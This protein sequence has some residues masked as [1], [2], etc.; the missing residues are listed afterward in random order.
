MIHSLLRCKGVVYID[1]R[2]CVQNSS[3]RF[4]IRSD[5]VILR[6][7]RQGTPAAKLS[8]GMSRVTTLPAPMTQLSPIVT[9][10]Q[11]VT[12]APNQQLSPMMTGFA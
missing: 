3:G 2:L 12:F 11:T 5:S 10:G 1:G 6:I 4:A 8:D 9:P 7:T